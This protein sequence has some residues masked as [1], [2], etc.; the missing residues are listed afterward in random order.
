M[1]L[2]EKLTFVAIGHTTNLN[3][4]TIFFKSEFSVDWKKYEGGNF[5]LD[6]YFIWLNKNHFNLI[7]TH[8][9]LYLSCKPKPSL[10][11]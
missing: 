10:K 5:Q 2:I 7:D 11:A 9:G 6:I 8:L 4:N 3:S 1:N